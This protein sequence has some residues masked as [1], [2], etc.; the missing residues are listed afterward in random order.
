[1]EVEGGGGGRNM[2]FGNDCVGLRRSLISPK[3][4]CLC[5]ISEQLVCCCVDLSKRSGRVSFDI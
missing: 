4:Y 1:M 3:W 5:Y 2:V